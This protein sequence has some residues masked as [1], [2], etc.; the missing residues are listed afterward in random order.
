MISTKELE[1]QYR[2]SN[3]PEIGI[4][5]ITKLTKE[6]NYKQAYKELQQLDS[7]TIKN[8][9][10]HLVLRIFL[11]S[12]LIN[13]KTQNLTLIENMIGEFSASNLISPQE[14]QWYKSLIL[15][16]R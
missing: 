5:Y 12:E 16:I 15:L 3:D 4:Q 11:N 13:T 14:T 9:N 6:F 7:I 2:T 8:M 10:P 1:Q